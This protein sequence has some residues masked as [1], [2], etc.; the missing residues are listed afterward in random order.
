MAEAR[1]A[2]P[3]VPLLARLARPGAR[4]LARGRGVA[5]RS[6]PMQ[7]DRHGQPGAA[8]PCGL[9][10]ARC[11]P[12]HA[13]PARPCTRASS[14]PTTHLCAALV[15][16]RRTEHVHLPLDIV[17]YP[18]RCPCVARLSQDMP[19]ARIVRVVCTCRRAPSHAPFRTHRAPR[20][21]CRTP[22]RAT[23]NHFT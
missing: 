23:I 5:R 6:R 1:G 14:K 2:A 9:A 8:C 7:R 20:L 17:V 4:G 11:G 18:R 15:R 3:L 10:L 16:V 22:Y 19:F 12:A 21:V 13:L